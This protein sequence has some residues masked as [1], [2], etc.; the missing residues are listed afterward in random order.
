[1]SEEIDK[2]RNQ[3]RKGMCRYALP[4]L[5]WLGVHKAWVDEHCDPE[6]M[7]DLTTADLSKLD[8]LI[9]EDKRLPVS[10]KMELSE[11]E[12]AGVKCEIEAMYKLIGVDNFCKFLVEH[13]AM[14]IAL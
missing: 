9:R 12:E 11:M 5:M 7:Q 6:D 4:Q 13:M 8:N 1:M 10:W 2:H 14:Y 3:R